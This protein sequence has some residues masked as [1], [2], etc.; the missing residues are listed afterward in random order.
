MSLLELQRLI[1]LQWLDATKLIDIV[2]LCNTKML[3]CEPQ[4]RQFG[5]HL[6]DEVRG[7]TFIAISAAFTKPR[8]TAFI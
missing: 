7:T 3:R 5:I 4:L 1:D 6:T 2:A 8:L